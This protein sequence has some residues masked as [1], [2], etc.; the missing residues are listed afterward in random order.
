MFDKSRADETRCCG[1]VIYGVLRHSDES[2]G[3]GLPT[4][5]RKASAVADDLLEPSEES[6]E[7]TVPKR[8]DGEE[9][10]VAVDKEGNEETSSKARTINTI[11]GVLTVTDGT[12]RL[13]S[14]H[15]VPVHPRRRRR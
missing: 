13:S 8:E 7:E 2:D 9:S 5:L 3:D 1:V 11:S 10:I 15:S 14:H 6:E 12:C 4:E